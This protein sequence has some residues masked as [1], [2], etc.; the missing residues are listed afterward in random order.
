MLFG[1][2]SGVGQGMDILDSGDRREFVES[3][4]NQ[5]GLRC[6]F[7]RERYALLKFEDL[8]LVSLC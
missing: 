1:M 6:I 8:G 5:W 4:C 7:M 3:C 2:V